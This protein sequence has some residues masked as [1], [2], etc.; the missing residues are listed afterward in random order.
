MECIDCG[1]PTASKSRKR[2]EKCRQIAENAS[3]ARN[4]ERMKAQR[5]A[6]R[7]LNPYRCITGCG[8]EVTVKNMMCESCRAKKRKVQKVCRDKAKEAA[9]YIVPDVPKPHKYS[10]TWRTAEQIDAEAR[11]EDRRLA[12]VLPTLNPVLLAARNLPSWIIP[13]PGVQI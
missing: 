3:T 9:A 7:T 4:N 10:K 12:K 2:C 6:Y 11:R 8:A 1:K 13:M 5:A